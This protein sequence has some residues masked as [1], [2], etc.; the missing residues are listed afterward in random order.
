MAKQ[1][2]NQRIGELQEELSRMSELFENTKINYQ[3]LDP[4]GIIRYV[5]R[6]WLACLGYFPHQVIGKQFES[7]LSKASAELYLKNMQALKRRRPER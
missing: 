5:N 7:F 2:T 4:K 3:L 6:S 1:E